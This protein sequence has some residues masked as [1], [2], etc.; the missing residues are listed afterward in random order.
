[1][2]I[3]TLVEINHDQLHALKWDVEFWEN[4]VAQLGGTHYSS[5]LIEANGRP[6]DIG[7]GVRIIMQRHHS[8]ECSVKSE[9][10]EV[11]L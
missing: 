5:R 11:K 7:H 10:E 3:R 4:L 2:S 6:I 1:M 8:T 9:Y